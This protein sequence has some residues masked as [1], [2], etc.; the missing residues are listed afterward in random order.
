MEKRYKILIILFFSL[1]TAKQSV[2]CQSTIGIEVGYGFPWATDE[3]SD[4]NINVLDNGIREIETFRMSHGTGMY[5]SLSIKHPINSLLEGKCLFSY[6]D[7]TNVTKTIQFPTTSTKESHKGNM[8]W[9]SP[10]LVFNLNKKKITPY[11]FVGFMVG[12]AG[13]ITRERETRSTNKLTESKSVYS[14]GTALGISSGLGMKLYPVKGSKWGLFFEAKI[15]SSSYA[16]KRGELVK[17]TI[18]GEDLLNSISVNESVV[19]YKDKYTIDES[20]PSDP[21]EPAIFSR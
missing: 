11:A 6:L 5:Y 21:D 17:Y 12:I 4:G 20:I 1:L 16:P 18:D 3:I 10:T 8:F 13:K 7:G 14:H 2:L 9:I 19:V 15:I